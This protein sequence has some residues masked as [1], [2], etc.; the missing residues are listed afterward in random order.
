MSVDRIKIEIFCKVLAR[1]FWIGG[2]EYIGPIVPIDGS[3]LN[4]VDD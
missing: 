3:F 1:I 4:L 2:E